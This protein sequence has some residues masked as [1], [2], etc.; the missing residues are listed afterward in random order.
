MPG[1]TSVT[2]I[3]KN[4][5]ALSVKWHYTLLPMW[6]MTYKYG[7]KDYYFAMNGQSRKIAGKIPISIPRLLG[8]AGALT[9]VAG[10]IA[11]IIM[12]SLDNKGEKNE[13]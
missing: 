13:K 6:L 8:F 10:L 3:S 9:A 11:Y 4:V 1:Y 2:P 12:A 7:G 5:T